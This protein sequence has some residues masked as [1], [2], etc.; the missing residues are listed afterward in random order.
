VLGAND[1]ARAFFKSKG[2]CASEQLDELLPDKHVVV[3]WNAADT[4]EEERRKAQAICGF[5]ARG[6][7]VIVLSTSSWSWPELCDVKIGPTRRFS[8]VFLHKPVT[9]PM[10][11]GIDPEWLI[12]WNGFPGTVGLAPLE[13]PAMDG[14]EKILWAREPNTTLAAALPAAE[15]DGRILFLQLD[16]QRRV[17]PSKPYYDP[18]AER[19]LLNLL[20]E[21][22]R[23]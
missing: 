6:G 18:T 14:A 9:H 21:R 19:L 3:I 1:S 17:D 2:L 12:R 15:G 13:G 8:R 10:L 20:S 4:T 16:I 7:R 23:P 5:A 22:N 11:A